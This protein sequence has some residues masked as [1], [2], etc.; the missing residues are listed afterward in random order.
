MAPSTTVME[1]RNSASQAAENLRATFSRLTIGSGN[2]RLLV[3]L[4]ESDTYQDFVSVQLLEFYNILT[5]IY[6]V[7]SYDCTKE[8]CPEMTAGSQHRYLWRDN[9]KYPQPTSMPAPDYIYMLFAYVKQQ[10]ER[11]PTDANESWPS[12]FDSIVKT[13]FR[14]LFRVFAHLYTKH[15]ETMEHCHIEQSVNSTL[16]HFLFFVKEYN[17]INESEFRPIANLCNDLLQRDTIN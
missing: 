2:L 9:D 3:Q 1:V 12:D 5:M 14:R 6:E 16:K 10:I 8:S 15:Y 11:F 13:C 4:P 17:L 7:V